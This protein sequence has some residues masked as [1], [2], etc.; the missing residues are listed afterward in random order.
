MKK[1]KAIINVKTGEV[2]VVE[3]EMTDEEIEVRKKMQEREKKEFEEA[4][5]YQRFLEEKEKEGRK[6]YSDWKEKKRKEGK[7]ANK[8]IS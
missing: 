2:K 8:K 1:R 6:E 5:I 7:F 3:I 4:E